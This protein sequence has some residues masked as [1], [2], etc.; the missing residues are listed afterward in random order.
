MKM[1]C[2]GAETNSTL[3]RSGPWD[4]AKSQIVA[5]I[6]VINRKLI[7]IWPGI[8]Q[9]IIKDNGQIMQNNCPADLP[10]SVART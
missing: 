10:S 1:K 5:N 8:L 9:I 4:F 6:L 7:I 2:G 3:K